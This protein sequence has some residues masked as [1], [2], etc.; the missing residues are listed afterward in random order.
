[1]SGGEVCDW[2]ESHT[3]FSFKNETLFLVERLTD[4]VIEILFF[5]KHFLQNE[6][7][8]PYFEENS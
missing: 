1:M 5:N 7:W 4:M 6:Q 8:N 2:V 3:N